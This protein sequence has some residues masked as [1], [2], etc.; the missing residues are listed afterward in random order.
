VGGPNASQQ[1]LLDIRTLAIK[2]P[3]K[4]A[5]PRVSWF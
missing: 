2:G 3:A 4:I 1:L 5:V